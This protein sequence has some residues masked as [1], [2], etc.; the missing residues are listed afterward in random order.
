MQGSTYAIWLTVLSV[1]CLRYFCLFSAKI[2]FSEQFNYTNSPELFHS[3]EKERERPEVDIDAIA[4]DD[5]V[6][7]IAR[8]APDWKSDLVGHDPGVGETEAREKWDNFR[9]NTPEL[10]DYSW[11]RFVDLT[12]RWTVASRWSQHMSTRGIV[13]W[14]DGKDFERLQSIINEDTLRSYTSLALCQIPQP[15]ATDH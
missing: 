13:S 11:S 3:W 14:A 15:E 4:A 9:F 10:M 6:Q 12:V 2:V 1:F 8:N 5:L 7:E